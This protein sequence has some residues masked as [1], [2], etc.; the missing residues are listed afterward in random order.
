MNTCAGGADLPDF[1]SGPFN[2]RDAY[3]QCMDYAFEQV[4]TGATDYN[5]AI[6]RATKNL[7]DMGVRVIDYESGVHTSLEAA[8]R[9][10]IMGGAAPF[11]NS[12]CSR[13]PRLPRPRA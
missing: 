1:E 5:T 4:F 12:V 2:L 11:C 3:R 7:A 9:R 10:N 8:V 6:R 13:R